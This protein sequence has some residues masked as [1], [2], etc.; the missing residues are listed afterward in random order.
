MMQNRFKIFVASS[1]LQND[2]DH[3]K[4]IL[5]KVINVYKHQ[6]RN[7]QNVHPV[8]HWKSRLEYVSRVLVQP[9]SKIVLLVESWKRV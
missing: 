7:I 2:S 5:A 1:N 8:V 3:N 9:I 4:W 6:E